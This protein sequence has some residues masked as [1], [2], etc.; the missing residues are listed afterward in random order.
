V[1]YVKRC[2]ERKEDTED[3]RPPSDHQVCVVDSMGRSIITVAAVAVTGG[4]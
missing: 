1:P 3:G 4:R 2:N